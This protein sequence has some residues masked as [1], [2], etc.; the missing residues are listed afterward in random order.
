M[1]KKRTVFVLGAGSSAAYGFSSGEA[2]LQTARSL[3]PEALAEHTQG[4]MTRQALLPIHNALQ[5]TA[6]ASIDAMLEHQ[7]THWP[8]L[9]A[10][11]AALLL[12][13]EQGALHRG[14]EVNEDWIGLVI[15]N[16][17]ADARSIEQFADNPVSF[18][19]FNYDR[20]L[21]YRIG[22]SLAQHYNISE[23]NVWQALRNMPLIH[24]HGTLGKLPEQQLAHAEKPIPFGAT[25]DGDTAYKSLAIRAAMLGTKIIH[26]IAEDDQTFLTVRHFLQGAEQVVFLGF[27]FNADN[28]RHLGT[29]AAIGDKAHVYGTTYQMTEA[30]V[31]V[32]VVPA[33]NRP[34]T[35]I[36]RDMK[37]KQFLREHIDILR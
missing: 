28:V 33:F 34:T 13:E 15:Q 17:A 23:P 1:I 5:R 20:F 14:I 27:S 9:K 36:F 30:E 25:D 11:M 32:D 2:L 31:R 16:M 21:E 18:V 26:E 8:A 12:E 35:R 6:M 24:L 29:Y 4:V 37:A 7:S 10:V 22:Q 3:S 19:S